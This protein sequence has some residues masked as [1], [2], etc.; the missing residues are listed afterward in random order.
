MPES[1]LTEE[2]AIPPAG[3]ILVA[4][5]PAG[6]ASGVNVTGIPGCMAG[7]SS[8]QGMTID[9][10]TPAGDDPMFSAHRDA[11]P[12]TELLVERDIPVLIH[13]GRRRSLPAGTRCTSHLAI[14]QDHASK[15][16]SR[17]VD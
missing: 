1:S 5:I 10:T 2:A 11:R 7:Q 9:T 16:H 14:P 17:K 15:L 12:F 3:D 13:S 8:A 4:R 6:H